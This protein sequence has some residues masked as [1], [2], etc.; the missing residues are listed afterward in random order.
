MKKFILGQWVAALL[1]CV[2]TFSCASS[3][4]TTDM[5]DSGYEALMTDRYGDEGECH[6]N[7]DKSF[8]LCNSALLIMEQTPGIRFFT[9]SIM[10]ARITY[11]SD[12]TCSAVSW[13]DAH[14]VEV[15]QFQGTVKKDEAQ[16]VPS[17]FTLDVRTGERQSL[18]Q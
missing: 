9:Y 5:A 12:T 1:L 11:E 18:N 14:H 15:L 8:V 17:G 6:P 3:P 10:E 4:K 2:L 7:E 16:G 13:L